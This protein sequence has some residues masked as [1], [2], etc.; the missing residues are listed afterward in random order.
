MSNPENKTVNKMNRFLLLIVLSLITLTVNAQYTQIPDAN[1]EAALSS[2]DDIPNDGQILTA[3]IVGVTELLLENSNISDVTGIEDFVALTSLNLSNNNITSIDISKNILLENLQISNCSALETIVFGD[4]KELVD[5][6][7]TGTLIESL[8]LSPFA[9][10]TEINVSNNNLSY[11]NIQTGTTG[12]I[13]NFNAKNNPNLSCILVDSLG[14]SSNWQND[15]DTGVTFST[16]YCRYTN[17]PDTAF[18][19]I[20]EDQGYDDISGDG[21][22]PTS[23]IETIRHLDLDYSAYKIKDLTGIEDFKAV[24]SIFG[25]GN[26]ITTADFSSNL[27]L[28]E[29]YLEDSPLE[30]LNVTSNT[31]LSGI[32]LKGATFETI[33][34]SKNTALTHLSIDSSS[35]SSIDLSSNTE[36][37]SLKLTNVN[38]STVDLSANINLQTVYLNQGNFTNLDF[39]KNTKLKSI[40]VFD[41]SLRSLNIKND[42]N[43]SITSFRAYGNANLTCI[44]VSDKNHFETR[45][46]GHID[47]QS[48]FTDHD[49]RYTNIP[50]TA[51]ET[52]LEDQGH[53]DISGDGQ[54]PTSRIETIRHLDLDYSAYK[55]KD[56]TGIED[57]KAVRSIFGDGNEITTAD[58]S[59]NLNLL[60][61]YLEDSPLE[62]LNVTSNTKL[63]GIFLKGATFETIDVSKN[64]ALTHLSI[65]SSSLSSIDLS[66][67][68]ELKSLS[69]TNVNLSNVDLSANINLQTV[70]LNQGNFTNLDFSKNTKLK[71]IW[72]FDNS[73]R[74]LNIKNDT[75]AS[76]TSFRAY[77]NANLTCIA[78]SDK[79]HFETRFSGHIDNQSYF[80]DHDCRYTTIPD[81]DFEAALEALKYDDISGDGQ[82]PTALIENVID[83]DISGKSIADVTGIEGFVSLETLRAASNDLISVDVSSNT[84][85][86]NL[87]LRTNDIENIDLSSNILLEEVVVLRNKLSSINVQNCTALKRLV[88]QD[89]L[90][91]AIDLSTNTA[92]ED[93]GISSNK[94][95]SID[96]S[97]NTSLTNLE[98]GGNELTSLDL[99]LN[100]DLE[101]IS[102]DDNNLERL[103]I[104]NGNNSNISLFESPGNENLTCIIVD[105]AEYATANWDEI[106]DHTQ[107]TDTEYCGYTQIPDSNFEAYLFSEKYDDIENDGQVPTELIEGITELDI[108]NN[109]IA[110]LT[111]IEGFTALQTLYAMDNTIA[112]IDLSFNTKLRRVELNGN[113]LTAIDLSKNTSLVNVVLSNTEISSVDLSLNTNLRSLEMNES[114]IRTLDF[115]NN[116]K[117]ENIELQNNTDLEKITLG[118]ISTLIWINVSNNKLTSLDVSKL[119]DLRRLFINNNNLTALN[120]KNGNNHNM[121]VNTTGNPDLDCIVVD[122]ATAD[123]MSWQL[124]NHTSFSETYCRYTAIPDA[125]FEAALELRDYDNISGDGQVPT[126][127]IEN[128]TYLSLINTGIS[129]VTGIEDFKALETLRL[130]SNNL[131]SIDLTQNINLKVLYLFDNNLSVIDLSKNT[132]LEDLNLAKNELT[133]VDLSKNIALKEIDVSRNNFSAIDLHL[134]T[135]LEDIDV[136]H[137][138]LTNLDVSA[139]IVLDN[140]DA[141]NTTLSSIDLSK[142]TLLKNVEIENSATIESIN[143]SG[144]TLLEYLY[145]NGSNITALDTS[146][147]SALEYIGIEG[148]ATITSLDISNNPSINSLDLNNCTALTT[149]TFGENPSLRTVDGENT[150]LT[151]M[152]VSSLTNL[153][154]LKLQGSKIK[155]LDLS[156]NLNLTELQVS[157]GELTQLNIKNDANEN[158]TVFDITGNLNLTCV[159]VDDATYSTA[160]W[161]SIDSQTTFSENCES[162]SMNA[163]V[164]LEGPFNNLSL[165]MNN[166]LRDNDLLPT[167]SPYSDGATCEAS[168]FESSNVVDWVEIQLRSVDDINI[169]IAAKSFLLQNNSGVRTTD[170]SSSLSITA[171]HGSYYVAIAHRNHLTVVTKDPITFD[172]DEANI[173]FTSDVNVL[174]GINALVDVANSIFALPAGNVDGSGQ[175]QNS[176]VNNTI[177][178]IGNSGYSLFDLDMNGQIQNTDINLI[179]KNLGKGEQF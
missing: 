32:F 7:I 2:Y 44:A 134:L 149:I 51:F 175:I 120:L 8:D 131:T 94:L 58:F 20:L 75:N 133:A 148:N 37:K 56:L 72:V 39:S 107:F 158:I 118:A 42:T 61:I 33:D 5:F 127:L 90:L 119:P 41:N 139:N 95:T 1:F 34:V 102:V 141:S 103:R 129:D 78:V 162:C 38:L 83:L 60:E 29:I 86:K 104:N 135:A 54:V 87:D 10:L 30:S 35:L 80:T 150:G 178:Q 146:D 59:S 151:S 105:D 116:S 92:L 166:D 16:T 71:S 91:T 168:V 111:G 113:P 74:S 43:A 117:L 57:F 88:V 25:D 157:N 143:I 26:E 13:N 40:W 17:I 85:L 68:T 67:N 125:N 76:I 36:L 66:S 69:L 12:F 167:T 155:V 109:S 163:R 52:I 147:N 62:S 70:Y 165:K 172:G 100:T 93:L 138:E 82:V 112:T 22:V 145:L 53:D 21:Q 144:L 15:V 73:L 81:A 27:N 121:S 159:Q 170:G 97:K 130:G 99:S 106:D 77:G 65:D 24:R 153:S 48:Y 18:E 156:G 142:N 122:S 64:T 161:A 110:N 4:N 123:N 124:D 132:H 46:S 28:L 114:S 176:G 126:A 6:S 137:N 45:F 9:F 115:S 128:L 136:S 160:N 31:K 47:N 11:L 63:S 55:I 171:W 23:R 154:K 164:I 169:V 14:I 98:L 108:R 173:D 152:D 179:R 174:N 101:N 84:K 177:L 3:N 140:L 89:N 79:N 19:A 50:D 96:V 49:C